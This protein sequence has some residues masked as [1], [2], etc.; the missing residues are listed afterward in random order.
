MNE[1]GQNQCA[2]SRSIDP[3][4]LSPRFFEVSSMRMIR[5]VYNF[6]PV[7]TSLQ[8]WYR[9]AD[10]FGLSSASISDSSPQHARRGSRLVEYGWSALKQVLMLT[11]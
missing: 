10:P 4:L 6:T 5:T 8:D 7:K 9:L 2:I 11:L 3:R 1:I